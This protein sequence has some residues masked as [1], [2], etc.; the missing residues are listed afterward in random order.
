MVL[1]FT[2]KELNTEGSGTIE[3]VLK[4]KNTSKE[5]LEGSIDITSATN[6][7]IVVQRNPKAIKLKANDSLFIVIKAI[8]TR[9][10]SP[11]KP[12]N[13]VASF[14]D[15]KTTEKTST[16]MAVQIRE[17]RLVRMLLSESNYFYERTGDTI[18]IPIR[19]TNDGNTTESITILTRFPELISELK[20]NVFT[21]QAYSD[22]L[23]ILKKRITREIMAKENFPIGISALYKNGYIIGFATM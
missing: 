9:K 11:Q 1:S 13:V 23:V 2:T 6:D 14:V 10:A 18:Q 17:K 5:T 12:I 8:V 20:K 3:T 16:S 22:T 4:L 19:F 15:L 21:I 7:L